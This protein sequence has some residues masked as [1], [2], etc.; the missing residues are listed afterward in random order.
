MDS[1]LE[2]LHALGGFYLRLGDGSRALA[3]VAVAAEAAP[4][5]LD[6]AA[7]LIRCYLALGQS[8]AALRHMENLT[9]RVPLPAGDTRLDELRV[10]ALWMAG[11]RQEARRLHERL[12][13]HHDQGKRS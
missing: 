13:V 11:R 10:R 7:T 2:V 12:R 3:L 5:N 6:L 9:S 8:E 1:R 4:G